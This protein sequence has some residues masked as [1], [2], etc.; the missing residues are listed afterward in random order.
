M[1]THTITVIGRD[2]RELA[3]QLIDEAMKLYRGG[4][5]VGPPVRTVGTDE[6]FTQLD[7][8][9]IIQAGVGLVM[10]LNLASGSSG[11]LDLYK[12]LEAY[13]L[14]PDKRTQINEVLKR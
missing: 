8:A 4:M 5:Y 12:L 6:T 14:D 7:R 10:H 11:D 3:R 9:Q 2:E 13:L 1:T